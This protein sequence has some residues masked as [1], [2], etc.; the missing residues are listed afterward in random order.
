MGFSLISIHI[1]VPT[2]Q[3]IFKIGT[4]DHSGPAHVP[5]CKTLGF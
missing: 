3:A 2:N 5:A 1:A 4:S